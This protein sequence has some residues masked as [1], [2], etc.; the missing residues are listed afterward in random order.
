[1][2]DEIAAA[3]IGAGVAIGTIL[4]KDIG[5]GLIQAARARKRSRLDAVEAYLQPI[6]NAAESLFWRLRE[7]LDPNAPPNFIMPGAIETEFK[8]YKLT[9][10]AYRFAALI[11]WT[12][13]LRRELLFLRSEDVDAEQKLDQALGR[14][15]AA[16]ADGQQLEL[17]R[18]SLLVEEWCLDNRH[19]LDMERVAHRVDSYLQQHF[20]AGMHRHTVRD[21]ESK[22]QKR[23]V[24]E[25]AGVVCKALDISPLPDTIVEAS[26][27]K[28]VG[29]IGIREHWVY[30]DMQA[31]IGDD[32]VEVVEHPSAIRRFDVAGYGS[33]LEL[34]GSGGGPP[35]SVLSCWWD[36][37]PTSTCGRVGP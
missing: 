9:S 13:A 11:G 32:M 31:A 17:L 28:A 36:S 24:S 7:V 18:A 27:A 10:T 23:L 8:R 5:W 21:M 29:I 25:V 37:W 15:S 3:T 4:L 26:L 19:P 12:R 14:I 6:C 22:D 20:S 30:R 1:M 35:P 16:L 34:L 33:F 2:S